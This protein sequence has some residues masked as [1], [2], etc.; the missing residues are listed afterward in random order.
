MREGRAFRLRAV[1]VSWL[2]AALVMVRL[3]GLSRTGPTAFD[4][5]ASV[6]LAAR[7]LWL[8]RVSSG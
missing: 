1:L 6:A 4:A 7:F 5:A 2:L 8:A 3:V